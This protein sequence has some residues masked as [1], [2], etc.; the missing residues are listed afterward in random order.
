[1]LHDRKNPGIELIHPKTQLELFTAQP[2]CDLLAKLKPLIGLHLPV[3]PVLPEKGFYRGSPEQNSPPIPANEVLP[4]K[5]DLTDSLESDRLACITNLYTT[6]KLLEHKNPRVF[7][8]SVAVS[9]R[10]T[11][12]EALEL[13]VEDSN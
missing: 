11:S 5:T 3:L 1:L 13:T 4:F 12:L 6:Q 10:T 9:A 2:I 8:T 7:T